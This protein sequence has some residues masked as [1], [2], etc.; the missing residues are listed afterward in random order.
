MQ[1]LTICIHKVH[2]IK[3]YLLLHI[4]R[5]QSL[6]WLISVHTLRLTTQSLLH[7]VKVHAINH[8]THPV[9]YAITHYIYMQTYSRLSLMIYRHSPWNHSIYAV[10]IWSR[11]SLT[12]CN[13]IYRQCNQTLCIRIFHSTTHY[14]KSRYVVTY[15]IQSL[16][17][18]S[19][20]FHAIT[21]YIQSHIPVNDSTGAT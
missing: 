12:T 11:Q 7:A 5:N 16:T 4:A 6:Y 19:H 15:S 21:H 17:I 8:Y 1:S 20:I 14:M 3:H 13:H 10:I 2:A 9:F 18:C